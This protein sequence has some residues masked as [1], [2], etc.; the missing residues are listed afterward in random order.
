MP[1]L[2]VI[3]SYDLAAADPETQKDM[4][5]ALVKCTEPKGHPFVPDEMCQ[6][7]KWLMFYRLAGEMEL[8]DRRLRDTGPATG[9]MYGDDESADMGEW[10]C[11]LWYKHFN[12]VETL[13]ALMMVTRRMGIPFNRFRTP[14]YEPPYVAEIRRRYLMLMRHWV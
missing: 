3:D 7:A 9:P 13:T 1:M 4:M 8:H 6:G 12:Q 10:I 2:Q 14:E 11:E 5:G